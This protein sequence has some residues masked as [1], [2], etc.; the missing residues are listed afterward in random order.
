[1]A[2]AGRRPRTPDSGLRRR[3]RRPGARPFSPVGDVDGRSGQ[4]VAIRAKTRAALAIAGAKRS[5][6]DRRT[7]PR[8]VS[9][10]D[11]EALAA[12]AGS[13]SRPS[14]R[15]S[16]QLGIVIAL[17]MQR[18]PSHDRPSTFFRERGAYLSPGE[19]VYAATPGVLPPMTDDQMPNRLGPGALAGEPGQPAHRAR[20]RQS[21][22]GAVLRPRHRRDER[23]LRHAGRAAVASRSCSTGS[24][25]SSFA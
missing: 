3:Q 17:V 14:A 7:H 11:A 5:P 12:D 2:V 25:P 13:R 9:R 20:H 21:R 24:R 22:L 1:M 16:R 18:G 23:G 15:S 8:R 4:A 6:D 10:P 19:R